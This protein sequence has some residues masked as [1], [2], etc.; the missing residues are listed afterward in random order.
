MR[1][2][3][4]LIILMGI[5]MGVL[6][7]FQN[8]SDVQFSEADDLA[9]VKLG[10]AELVVYKFDP[11]RSEFRP[12]INLT[13]II[14]NSQ[15]MQLIQNQMGAAFTG[16]ADKLKGFS[17]Q[18]KI[19]TTTQDDLG[20]KS[21]VVSKAFLNYKDAEGVDQK[22]EYVNEAQIMELVPLGGA[23]SISQEHILAQPFTT[24][25][26][27]LDF[28]S[29]M[30]D[31]NFSQFKNSFNASVVAIG[32]NG[33]NKEQPFCTLLRSLKD[34]VKEGEYQAFI[35]AS[36]ED[37]QTT[38]DSCLGSEIRNYD[39]V[40]NIETIG[41]QSED[42]LCTSGANCKFN[43]H[44]NFK[45]RLKKKIQ[46]KT[47]YYR[48][49]ARFKFNNEGYNYKFKGSWNSYSQSASYRLKKHDQSISFSKKVVT[50]V[51]GIPSESV[52]PI[53]ITYVQNASGDCQNSSPPTDIS[54][55]VCSTV[56]INFANTSPGMDGG[57][58]V[59]DSCEVIC[60]NKPSNVISE[61]V[62]PSIL[63]QCSDQ[64]MVSG[65]E[66]DCGDNLALDA[67][68]SE[69]VPGSC[70]YSCE[71]EYENRSRTVTYES[72]DNI[73]M[74]DVCTSDD[75]DYLDNHE[76]LITA[77]N[78]I[79]VQCEVVSCTAKNDSSYSTFN[80][81]YPVFDSE[82]NLVTR[83]PEFEAKG[84]DPSV[85]RPCTEAD[86]LKIISNNRWKS[87]G[88]DEFA[89]CEV[90]AYESS[91]RT[92]TDWASSDKNK[93]FHYIL[94]EDTLEVGPDSTAANAN[95][96]WQACTQVELDRVRDRHLT[97]YKEMVDGTCEYRIEKV[98]PSACDQASVSGEQACDTGS[99]FLNTCNASYSN[100]SVE[101]TSCKHDDQGVMTVATP[102][103]INEH[104]DLV[105]SNT[106]VVNHIRDVENSPVISSVQSAFNDLNTG[107]FLASFV[108][109]PGDE[110]C[111]PGGINPY[112]VKHKTLIDSLGS[113]GQLFSNC[114]EDYSPALEFVFDLIVRDVG[115]SYVVDY[116][117]GTDR[118]YTVIF[119]YY[120][121]TSREVAEGDFEF[122]SN[123]IVS[124]KSV[125]LFE[126]VKSIEVQVIKP[127]AR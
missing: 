72:C 36:N 43:Y 79:N 3:N 14:D 61:S 56:D 123:S 98:T 8:C 41:N 51:D 39:K 38:V 48:E 62:S 104:A 27:H 15:S 89:S 10:A 83:W 25:G 112:G 31:S 102:D 63:G 90:R 103:I 110:S 69:M 84:L 29:S 68:L 9:A 88:L 21:S 94:P 28:S 49:N 52:V 93:N 47:R 101:T 126:N 67:E 127:L 1:R 40:L 42:A 37:D 4:A 55:R 54:K 44:A 22:I 91:L 86:K 34:N 30:S 118:I 5:L 45:P 11:N 65:E 32:V 121:G 73:A 82:N 97:Y 108:N 85:N 24:S 7:T 87:R 92:R 99:S 80:V 113:N 53:S 105:Y 119:N 75:I 78:K 120:D 115:R 74:G 117:P 109:I 125:D 35:I 33:S 6:L 106:E 95:G 116:I 71:Q 60:T 12:K 124:F 17:G 96:S 23:Y 2:Q 46:F 70:H 16:V 64:S 50:Y 111:L 20:E 18:V 19:F 13:T 100:Y 59:P 81:A 66:Y 26:S 122:S 76:Q 107:Y 57:T 58:L 77:T 114:A